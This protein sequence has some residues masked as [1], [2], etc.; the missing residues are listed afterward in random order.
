MLWHQELK[1]VFTVW[2]H[3]NDSSKVDLVIGENVWGAVQMEN[4]VIA[5]R[6]I[7]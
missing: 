5:K 4:G 1:R 7:A 3:V 6:G 2:M